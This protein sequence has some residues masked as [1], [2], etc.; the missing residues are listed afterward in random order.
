MPL[1]IPEIEASLQ[2]EMLTCSE[3]QTRSRTL[4]AE[5]VPAQALRFAIECEHVF[6]MDLHFPVNQ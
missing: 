6:F 5:G 3:C 4:P 2:N 1:T